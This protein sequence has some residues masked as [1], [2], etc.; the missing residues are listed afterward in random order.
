MVW[1]AGLGVSGEASRGDIGVDVIGEC[2]KPV[3]R[4]E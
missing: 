1:G 4:D 3:G 2:R